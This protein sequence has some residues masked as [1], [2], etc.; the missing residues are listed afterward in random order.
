MAL[1]G[2]LVWTEVP[3]LPAAEEATEEA[4]AERE[5]KA[6]VA[7][8]APLLACDSRLVAAAEALATIELTPVPASEVNEL[9]TLAAPPVAVLKI[10]AAPSVAVPKTEVASEA[11]CPPTEVMSLMMLDT[12]LIQP[13]SAL[14]STQ[15]HQSSCLH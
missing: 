2:R 15:Q 12:A 8:E 10:L 9:N 6:L 7:D 4:L 13:L 5:L 1:R 11:T 14:F 3:A